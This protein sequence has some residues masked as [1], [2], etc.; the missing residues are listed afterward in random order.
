MWF[1]VLLP[2]MDKLEVIFKGEA[3]NS[4]PNCVGV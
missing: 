1:E 4:W 3:A 2:L